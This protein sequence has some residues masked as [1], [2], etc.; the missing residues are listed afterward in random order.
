MPDLA[1]HILAYVVWL[2]RTYC[3]DPADAANLAHL[4]AVLDLRAFAGERWYDAASGLAH[5]W[6]VIMD[7]WLD[8]L[9]PYPSRR[10]DH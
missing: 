10:G 4:R 7:N 9:D 2:Y 1:L 5:W 6:A 8:I 3:P